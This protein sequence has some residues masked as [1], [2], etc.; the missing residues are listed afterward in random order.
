MTEQIWDKKREICV[1][2][3]HGGATVSPTRSL[4]VYWTPL[5]AAVHAPNS[6]NGYYRQS[7]EHKWVRFKWNLNSWVV[8]L[9]FHFPCVQRL[10]VRAVCAG[11]GGVRP[12]SGASIEPNKR[13]G[14][15]AIAGAL[16]GAVSRV[17]VGPLDVVKIRMQVQ[18]EPVRAGTVSKYTGIGQAI[19]CILREEGI[20][21]R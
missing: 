10:R 5:R 9:P 15:D 4:P 12:P 18:R 16:A 13:A 2:P 17:V 1:L 8:C 3:R 21:V 20:S 19:R 7:R 6:L 14:L 11:M